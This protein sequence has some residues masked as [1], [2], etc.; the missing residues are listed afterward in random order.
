MITVEQIN[1][2][3]EAAKPSIVESFKK[4]IK[5]SI[6]WDV[7]NTASKIVVEETTK[8]VKENIVPELIKQLVESKDGLISIGIKSSDEIVKILCES[9]TTALSEKLKDSW[10]RKE[11]LGKIF[12]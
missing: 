9:L 5:D 12:E 4:E 1:E 3:L 10:R 6:S 2:M 11:V 8:W 7:K